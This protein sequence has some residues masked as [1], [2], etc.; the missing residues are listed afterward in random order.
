MCH[1]TCY[2]NS[3]QKWSKTHVS[4]RCLPLQSD[5]WCMDSYYATQS[6]ERE[7]V[8]SQQQRKILSINFCALKNIYIYIYIK[9]HKTVGTQWHSWLRHW[10]RWWKVAGLI[11][12][13]VSGNFRWH[14][15]SGRTMALGSTQPLN[16]NE[17]QEYLPGGKGG[18]CI[19]LTTLPPSRAECCEIWEAQHPGPLWTWIG[20]YRDC[21]TIN[22]HLLSPQ[23]LGFYKKIHSRS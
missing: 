9:I 5:E 17:Y 14:N 2:W 21:F 4:R 1:A 15:P 12:K 7:G 16:R 20:Q 3:L 13:D 10:A 19:G 23:N 6:A 18:R 8:Q 22:R 11:P